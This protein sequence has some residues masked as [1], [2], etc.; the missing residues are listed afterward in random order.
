[1]EKKKGDG[2]TT[3]RKTYGRRSGKRTSTVMIVSVAAAAVLVLVLFLILLGEVFFKTHF[4]WGTTVNGNSVAGMTVDQ[5]MDQ[6]STDIDGYTLLI[7]ERNGEGEKVTETMIGSEIGLRF[8]FDDSLDQAMDRQGSGGWLWN[9]GRKKEIEISAMVEYDESAWEK[10]L[11]SLQCFDSDFITKPVD[12]C[13]SD[14]EEGVGYEIIEELPGNQP[15]RTKVTEVL[16]E[17]VL[18]LESSVD[19]DE[20]DCY[21]TAAITSEDPSLTSLKEALEKYTNLTITYTFG[22]TVEELNGDI[23][24]EWLSVDEDDQITLDE[25]GVTDFVAGL[26]KKYDTIFR[27]RTF[28]TTYGEDVVLEDGD[29]GWWMNY[30]QEGEELL[31][32]VKA[33]E[34][35]ERTPVYYQTAAAYGDQDYGDTYIEVNLTAQ[36]LFFYKEGELVLESDFVSGNSSRGH[37]TPEGVYGITYKQTNATLVGEDYET[38]VSYWMP[39]NENVGLHD[40]TWRSEFGRNFYQSSGSHGCINLPYLTAKEIYSQV[41]AGTAV[42]CYNLEGTESDSVTEQGPEEIAQSA[43][44]AID[45]IG[46]VTNSK[47]CKDL[48][49][50]ARE[51]YDGL[52]SSERDYVDNYEVLK[53]AESE[54]ASLK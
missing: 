48:I 51:L 50:R 43:V 27:P 33:G 12:A 8:L 1:M 11:D 22:D 49:D 35:G 13:L 44:D 17:A 47:A 46:T 10:K 38:P 54:Y 15:D 3:Q 37:D 4:A 32:M 21:R 41:E 53:E 52:S 30:V 26:R 20:E 9:L 14:Y 25:E 6:L 34:S 36:H 18:H 5:V 39:F 19:L 28:H 7:Y 29:Y 31:A 24:H 40:A 45:N 23:I 2:Q 16:S 42:I